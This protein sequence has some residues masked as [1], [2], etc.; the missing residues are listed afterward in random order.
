MNR[1]VLEACLPCVAAIA[2]ALVLLRAVVWLSGAR[3][4]LARLREVHRCQEGGV[5]SLAFVITVP[6]FL[7]I[8]LF[9][10]QVSQLMVGVM[11]VNYAA[12]AAA[13]AA[14]VWIPA[15]VVRDSRFSGQSS[16]YYDVEAE[17]FLHVDDYSAD[18]TLLTVIPSDYSMKAPWIRAAAVLAVAPVCPSRDLGLTEQDLPFHLQQSL[19]STDLLY[20]AM[21]PSASSNSRVSPRLNNKITFAEANTLIALQWR[22]TATS[23]GTNT[24]T[25]PTYNPREHP[26]AASD[27]DLVW[28]PGEAGWQDAITVHV[29]HHF[30]LLP[31]PGRLLARQLVRSNGLPD[32]ISTRITREASSYSDV[33][34]TTPIT[35]SATFTNEGIRSL[36]P[37]THVL[38][39]S[40][41]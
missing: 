29:I 9:I 14:S 12:F 13:R 1:A 4:D 38:P 40:R 28:E 31:G 11:Q 20:H 21:V 32:N 2:A 41:P 39:V 24:T 25:S 6:V 36:R 19:S 22:D 35:A 34:Y 16:D 10:V 33:V 30:A 7:A 18:G 15:L 26:L 27:P 5:Q 37:L 23:N 8:L 3:L 17:N